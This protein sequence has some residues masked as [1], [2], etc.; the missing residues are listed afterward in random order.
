MAARRDGVRTTSREPAPGDVVGHRHSGQGGRSGD[1]EREPRAADLR[2]PAREQA[3]RRD[4]GEREQVE[5]DEPP[6]AGPARAE[7]DE[8][9]R[10]RGEE[11]ES[12][13]RP[14]SRHAREQRVLDRRQRERDHAEA[15]AA[16]REQPGRRDRNVAVTSAPASAPRPKGCREAEAL[17]P[18]VQ[19]L[20][21]EQR[22][23][24]VE[25]EADGAHD[26]HDGKDEP[27]LRVVPDERSARRVPSTIRADGS[28]ST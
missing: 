10:V 20:A 11:R 25:V 8:G 14:E 7:L 24:H 9:V 5:A 23:E 19:R 2:E 6:A 16:G 28:R 22:H 17:R 13:A 12:D 1:H 15:G 4:P 18:D 3:D 21:G 26:R 27:Q